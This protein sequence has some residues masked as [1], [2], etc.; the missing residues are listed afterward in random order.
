MR[1]STLTRQIAVINANCRQCA[2]K[3]PLVLIQSTFIRRP[4][5]APVSVR[6]VAS[7]QIVLLDNELGSHPGLFVARHITEHFVF[8]GR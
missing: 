1:A 7:S 4:Q 5:P 2:F 8:P 3:V 6:V